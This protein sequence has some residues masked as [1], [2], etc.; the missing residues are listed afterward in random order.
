MSSKIFTWRSNQIK[1]VYGDDSPLEWLSIKQ[2]ERYARLTEKIK[3]PCGFDE[4]GNCLG[5]KK[6]KTTT[7]SYRMKCCYLCYHMFGHHRVIHKKNIPMYMDLIKE[8]VGFWRYNGCA[9]PRYARSPTCLGFVCYAFSDYQKPR[10]LEFF[11][12]DVRNDVIHGHMCYTMINGETFKRSARYFKR[13]KKFTHLYKDQVPPGV[14]SME[15]EYYLKQ[16]CRQIVEVCNYCKNYEKY[17]YRCGVRDEEERMGKSVAD[18]AG[19]LEH[20]PA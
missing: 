2:Y 6:M 11:S 19:V 12:R 14:V 1:I 20:H 8:N 5:K 9:L 4:H 15:F 17:H 18:Q 10:I 16:G 13:N 7:L 3:Y